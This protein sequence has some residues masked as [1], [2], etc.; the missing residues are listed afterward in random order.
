MVD[1]WNIRAKWMRSA[2]IRVCFLATF[3]IDF[4][5]SVVNP[6]F[7]IYRRLIT[8]ANVLPTHSGLIDLPLSFLAGKIHHQS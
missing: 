7:V 2:G 6:Y 8:R 4:D 5:V 1:Q 3:S